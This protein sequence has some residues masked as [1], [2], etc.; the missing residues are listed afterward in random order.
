MGKVLEMTAEEVIQTISTAVFE[1][2]GTIVIQIQFFDE[3]SSFEYMLFS[4]AIKELG[5]EY[6]Y[7]EGYED[8]QGKERITGDWI[9]PYSPEDWRARFDIKTQEDILKEAEARRAAKK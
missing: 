1:F 2:E 6:E 9:T 3:V 8:I 5:I 4:K 7:Y